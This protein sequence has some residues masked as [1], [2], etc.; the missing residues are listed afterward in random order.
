MSRGL[1]GDI[2]HRGVEMVLGHHARTG[3]LE[4]MNLK[5]NV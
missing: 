3:G 4:A 2:A 1:L 5:S